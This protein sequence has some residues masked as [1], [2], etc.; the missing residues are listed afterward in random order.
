MKKQTSIF[1]V[2]YG[3]LVGGLLIAAVPIGLLAFIFYCVRVIS[4]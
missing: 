1:G 3:A 4:G 2:L